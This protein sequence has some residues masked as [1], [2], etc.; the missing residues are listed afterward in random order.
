MK[1][2]LVLGSGKWGKIV[3]DKLQL[4]ADIK[5]VI[6]SKKNYKD[7]NTNLIDWVFI[8]TPDTKHFSMVKFFLKKNINVFC[9]KP[10]TDSYFKSL[11][12]LKIAKKEKTNLYISDIEN[13]KK[14]KI[15]IKKKNHIIRTKKDKGSIKSI[16]YRLTYH[17]MYLL[18]PTFKKH[19]SLKIKIIESKNYLKFLVFNK[20]ISFDFFYSLKSNVK[21]HTVN[22]TSLHNVRVDV[23]SKMLNS[24]L[25][26]KINYKINHEAS[27][28]ASK[29]I[30]NVKKKL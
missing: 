5:A 9:E 21:I 20:N 22:N 6:N 30:E 2:I 25:Y 28:F 29:I 19:K 14:I 26:K 11:E 27:L 24:V 16:L 10:L 3:I 4:I 15:K 23:L 13:Y 17:D 8:L 18:Y 7:I 1:K 12:L